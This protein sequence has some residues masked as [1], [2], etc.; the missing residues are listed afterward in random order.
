MG[1]TGVGGSLSAA[2][3]VNL[4]SP[5][6]GESLRS[7][8]TYWANSPLTKTDVG[9]SNVDNTADIDKPVSTATQTALNL[10]VNTSSLATVATTGETLATAPAGSTIR[11]MSPTT[12][13]PTTRTDIT[14]I[15]VAYTTAPANAIQGDLWL[16][17][18]A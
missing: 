4:N 2:S 6:S 5:A 9:L 12:S 8:G 18:A 17:L 16:E 13:R 7:T 10:K 1:S 3:D 11:V 15:W 14:V